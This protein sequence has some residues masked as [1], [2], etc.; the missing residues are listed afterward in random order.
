MLNSRRSAVDHGAEGFETG[1]LGLT[2]HQKRKKQAVAEEWNVPQ[3]EPP[4]PTIID[5]KVTTEM[6]KMQDGK[7]PGGRGGTSDD[8]DSTAVGD[9]KS[10][11][12]SEYDV[13]FA[14][15]T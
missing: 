14:Q 8:D 4:Q 12:Y 5:I 10:K 6:V 7:Q 2:L 3:V 15:R 1:S 9:V 11:R 13:A